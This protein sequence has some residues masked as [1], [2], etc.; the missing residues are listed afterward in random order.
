VTRSWEIRYEGS[1]KGRWEGEATTYKYK[2]EAVRESE[3]ERERERD[4]SC[5][6]NIGW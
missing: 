3:S 5:L 1:R 6:L 2:R 4:E